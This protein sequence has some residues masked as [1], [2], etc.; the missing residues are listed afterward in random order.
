MA[1]LIN[2]LKTLL[3]IACLLFMSAPFLMEWRTF[4]KD[5]EKKISCKR[6]RLVLFTVV[7]II[8][9][10]VAMYLLKELLLWLE[11]L[12][13]M[14]WLANRLAVATRIDYCLKVFVAVL[15]NG[16]IGL[17]YV[18]LSK[19]VRI[20]MKKRR[21]KMSREE[22]GDDTPPRKKEGAV[23]R[24]FNK[25]I[26]FFVGRVFQWLFIV[27]GALYAL[28]Y[29]LYL[30]TAVF[31]A[32]WLPYGFVST[33]FTAGY[34]YPTITLLALCQISFFLRGIENVEAECPELSREEGAALS[35]TDTDLL[36]IDSEVK[37]QFADY[38]VGDLTIPASMGEHLSSAKHTAIT[39]SIAAAVEA[40][41]R[42]AQANK[43]VYL[44]CLDKITQTDKSVL[45]NGGFCSE[46][47]MYFLRY[48]SIILARGDNIAFV[49]NSDGE[50]DSTHA[51]IVQ[52]LSEISSLYCAAFA[53]NENFDHPIWKAVKVHSEADAIS[54]AEIN[55][56]SIL[57]TSLPYLCSD[58]F[59]QQHGNF[60]H[61]LDTVV[62]VDT[63]T[64]VNLSNRQLSMLNTRLK[65][66]FE[67]N[68]K[69][70]KNGSENEGY[71]VRYMAK[72]VR[73]I[74]FDSSSSP[75][76]DKVLENLL[77]VDFV[78]AD[79]MYFSTGTLVRFYNYEARPGENGRR[80][81]RQVVKTDEEIGTIMNMAIFCLAGGA[82][83]VTVLADK[84]IPY[85]NYM[86]TIAAHKGRIAVITDDNGIRINTYHYNPNAY[87][88]IIAMDTDDNLPMTVRK[89]MALA[90]GQP[91]L[92]M[93]FSRQHILRD[94][95][96]AN[97][98]TLWEGMTLE[99]IPV[100]SSTAKDVA[101]RI[102]VMAG[103]GGISA[104][105]VWQMV[106]TVPYFDAESKEQDMDGVLYKVLELYGIPLPESGVGLYDHF[107]YKTVR[108]F[109]A[110]G[111]FCSE[112]RIYLRENGKLYTKVNGK[113]TAR[114]K[115]GD[116]TFPL[117]V[118]AKRITQRYIEGQ[119]LLHDGAV[120]NIYKIDT[121]EG[122][123][124]A[125]L[126]T[127]G[128]ND[129]AYE[130]V[131][132]RE[133]R[134]EATA[135]K[136]ESV[137]PV[138]H[139]VLNETV[140]ETRVDDAYISVV[141]APAEVITSGYYVI[142][143]H[144]MSWGGNTRYY[145]IADTGDDSLLKQNYRK[146]GDFSAPTYRT[147]HVVQKAQL[148]SGSDGILMMNIKISGV[149][150]DSPAKAA[151]LAAA[152][153]DDILK[154]MFPSVAPSIAV[155][156]V[157]KAPLA[158]EESETVLKRHS[159]MTLVGDSEVFRGDDFE[160]VIIE[161][162]STDLGVISG[163]LSA[164]DDILYTLFSPVFA[165]LQWYNE[166]EEKSRYL[167]GPLDREPSCFD[168]GTLSAVS[169]I[170]GD[171][172][173]DIEYID[174][175][176]ITEYH[177][178]S[179]CGKKYPKSQPLSKLEDS[180][181]I[182]EEC[183]ANLVGNNKK[184][185]KA[186]F[187]AAKIF[188]ESTYGIVLDGSY[189]VCFDSTAKIIAALKKDKDSM[190]RGGDIPT[191]AY[192]DSKRCVHIEHSIPA[193]NLSEILVRELTYVWQLNNTPTVPEELAQ[194]HIALVG[195][196]YLRFLGHHTL[197]DARTRYYESNEDVSGKGYRK[198]AAELVNNPQYNNNPFRY[199]LSYTGRQE[200]DSVILPPGPR[201][202]EEGDY[203]LP[204]TPKQPDRAT[205]GN[206]VYFYYANLTA[207]RQ[208]AYDLMLEAIR[209]H[210][211]SVRVEDCSFEDIVQVSSAI[212]YDHPELFWY[213]NFSMCGQEVTLLYGATAE[214]AAVLQRRI[215]QEV[216][217][218]LEG[219]DDSMSA[220]DVAIRIH[221]RVIAAVDYDTIA[222]NKQ[223]QEGGPAEDKIDYLRTICG[224]FL[225]GTAV[226]EGYAR[227]MQYLLQKCGIE[228]AEAVGYIRKENGEPDG[229]HAW[230]M[231]KIDGD[232][233]YL[234]TTWDD[235]S[236]TIQ[237]VKKTDLG[238]DYFCIT[239]EE[240]CRTRDTRLCPVEMPLCKETRANYFYHNGYVLDGYDVAKIKEIAQ[241]AAQSKRTCFTIKC[242]TKPVFDTAMEKLC[243]QGSDCYEVL[244]AVGKQNKQILTNAY[245]YTYD[246][247]IWT[248]TV[249][250]KCK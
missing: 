17:L 191:K 28:V 29:A 153:L 76:L 126:T 89:C 98:E 216:P 115:I 18:V 23:I 222:L 136:L 198:L 232:Y 108:D 225:N 150:G 86:E 165:Y 179:F 51:Y 111:R 124:Y 196:Q 85:K 227:A 95:Y 127:S 231:V 186:Y 44:N 123:V 207:T 43:E 148:V 210:A 160:L 26:W 152:M 63:L 170:L 173:H 128:K 121:E 59:E 41:A 221:A 184:E 46:F 80:T 187:N 99:R 47:S 159:R 212:A 130:Y 122:V 105:E 33:L 154:A 197:A 242:K 103:A 238:F 71:R 235:G 8:L 93:I 129:D 164:G 92:V 60:I 94:Y 172:K 114:L 68:A 83:N 167:Y 97:I 64:T 176:T 56:C 213:K 246:S 209:T 74:C 224:V 146:Y 7:Y 243:A 142:D 190:R 101:R 113:E 25:E 158:D 135:E 239:T 20:G 161:D 106:S 112:R 34:M 143:P 147:E 14:V 66:I 120:Y 38:Y 72:Q 102:A 203:G 139:V 245:S 156:P 189:D 217:K 137:H 50:I 247:N 31:G 171:D 70:A 248:I 177:V 125:R 145:S 134:V 195:I 133:Y 2:L 193:A 175:A 237:S 15:M 174:I 1:F 250:F 166:A 32:S 132:T 220:Y 104:E 202:I 10:T 90:S 109:D 116:K 30:M 230:N 141:R 214:E 119:N 183:A 149:L 155:C 188:L 57:V 65:Q 5:K 73:Y 181:L 205:D 138:K 236:N 215:D 249:K 40:D 49:C 36:K 21:S 88:V 169:Q 144:T 48:L 151:N 6:F 96:L 218:Y 39:K 206:L 27:L 91:T 79:S 55:N 100:E 37:K 82:S 241:A 110:N 52:A 200:D 229:A 81:L 16:V 75:G 84:K 118:P 61:L 226:C 87:S 204:Y 228:T 9:I 19:P 178:C 240:L 219:I 140:G 13:V 67:S 58:G 211:Q 162:S 199:L 185:L 22:S 107:E 45:V 244:K 192:I 208:K 77:G 62:F 11:S 53:D 12:P 117:P 163:I 3:I 54:H 69:M 4:R 157:V 35:T 24:F 180:R 42:N 168:F 78:S 201:V 233:Y 194:G 223:K 131:Q 182:C 234:D